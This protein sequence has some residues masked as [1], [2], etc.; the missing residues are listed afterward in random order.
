M[1]PAEFFIVP[2]DAPHTF[3]VDADAEAPARFITEFRPA[4]RIAEFFAQ[5]FHLADNGEVDEKGRIHPLQLAVLA[6]EFPNE[7]FYSP[8]IPAAIHRRS[9]SRSPRSAA[10]ADTPPIRRASA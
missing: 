8:A 5:I 9:L 3:R 6:R 7:F 2:P 10:G 4:L 1:A